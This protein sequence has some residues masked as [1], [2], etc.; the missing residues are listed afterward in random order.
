MTNQFG[1]SGMRLALR[2]QFEPLQMTSPSI[3]GSEVENHAG[4][5]MVSASPNNNQERKR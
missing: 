3:N 4:K 1:N 5:W 2:C